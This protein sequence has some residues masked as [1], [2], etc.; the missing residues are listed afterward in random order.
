MIK[1]HINK[2]AKKP[3]SVAA[4]S[5]VKNISIITMIS[6]NSER[7]FIAAYDEFFPKIYNFILRTV[8]LPEVA[9]D[10]TSNAFTDA[11]KYIKTKNVEIKN[12]SAWM[13]KI[14]TNELLKYLNS[15][16]K[17][18]T[19]SIDDEK[20]QL[21][22]YLVDERSD[23]SESF[24]QYWTVKQALKKLKPEEAVIVEMHFFE[25]K[26]YEEMAEILDLKETT[27]RTRVHRILKKLEKIIA[28]GDRV[29]L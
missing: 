8:A 15:K 27:I 23:K 14:A 6:V 28:S 18:A 10:L 16:R 13:Y 12:F 17:K 29:K 26:K 24:A 2:W 9:E 1:E 22:N 5:E 25:D 3:P 11:L 20:I 21:G 7:D 4:F 19:L